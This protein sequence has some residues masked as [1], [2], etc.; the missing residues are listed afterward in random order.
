MTAAAMILSREVGV[1]PSRPAPL[2]VA[3]L[4][5]TIGVGGLAAL[6][7]DT[8]FGLSMAA[9]ATAIAGG[10]FWRLEKR[11]GSSFR[12]TVLV[13]LAFRYCMA[14]ANL[15]VGL[16]FYRGAVDFVTYNEIANEVG[17][18]LLGGD[19]SGHPVWGG[20]TGWLFSFVL[21]SLYLL[22]GSGYVGKFCVSTLAAFIGSYLFLKAFRSA[23]PELTSS[24]RL[25]AL[26]L[27]FLPSF[28]YWPSSLGKESW[29]TFFLGW[30]TYAFSRL[31]NHFSVGNVVMLLVGVAGTTVIRPPV[32]AIVVVAG[33]V[34]LLMTVGRRGPAAILR[35]VLVTGIV[36]LVVLA[37]VR[38]SS[39]ALGEKFVDS[40]M[41]ARG[42]V[43]ALYLQ[44]VG[45]ATD[46]TASGSSIA[47]QITEPTLGGVLRY[48]PLGIVTFLFR[49]FIFE[50]H[51]ALAVIAAL[52]S[53]FLLLFALLRSR[54]FL[55][56][57]RLAFFHPFAAFAALNFVMLSVVLSLESNFGAI[58]RHRSMALPFLLILLTMRPTPARVR[59]R[60]V[61][62]AQW[63]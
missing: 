63:S 10:V 18:K 46:P 21:G 37:A 59:E 44:H 14:L 57:L 42:L 8:I 55:A 15:G 16:W 20:I 30:T 24:Q 1:L 34:A 58:V 7:P 32:G 40:E 31:V 3:C 5:V 50:A 49:P 35:P 19:F 25:L 36:A 12:D 33:G 45:L 4:I 2:I 51:N 48:L 23:F 54:S 9:L 27:F 43:H 47:V 53:S 61:P 38:L 6:I 62:V 60:S 17:A 29:M 28:A 13:A 39:F 56:G 22:T 41:A 52:E 26:G 11:S